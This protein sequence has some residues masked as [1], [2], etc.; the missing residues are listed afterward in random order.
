MGDFAKTCPL[1]FHLDSGCSWNQAKLATL[2]PGGEGDPSFAQLLLLARLHLHLRYSHPPIII[3]V[4]IISA[5]THKAY[6]NLWTS[7]IKYSTLNAKRNG[8]NFKA[9]PE[10]WLRRRPICWWF[11]GGQLSKTAK[12]WGGGGKGDILYWHPQQAR[13]L[14]LSGK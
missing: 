8:Q 4:I 11:A 7:I 13:L 9:R 12:R 14:V 5:P 6:I 3:R 10:I 2:N 1:G